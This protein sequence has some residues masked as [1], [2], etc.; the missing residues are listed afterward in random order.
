MN[1]A[2]TTQPDPVEVYRAVTPADCAE[3]S[4][5]L[6]AVGIRSATLF[7]APFYVLSVEHS[8]AP[9]AREQL[10]LYER[11]RRQPA[12]PAAA[13][14]LAGHPHAWI[15]CLVYALVLV[16]VGLSVSNGLW[17]PDAFDLG[18]L[19]AGRVH[20]GEWWR[21][22]TA[23]T[24]HLNGEHLGANLLVGS[25]FGYLAGRQQGAGHAWFLVVTGAGISNWIEA[26]LAPPGYRAVGASTAVFTTLGLVSAYTWGTGARWSRR[27][28]LQWAPLVSGTVLLAW[29]GSGDTDSV[30]QVD[31]VAHALGFVAGVLIGIAAARPRLQRLT[32][33]IPQW[34]TG[35]LAVLEII[36]AWSLALHS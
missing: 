25:L 4:L 13:M 26:L 18:A 29:F 22:W 34:S 11:E 27:W 15:G 30:G 24:L 20:A 14:R 16:N 12:P 23:L 10:A 35:M 6:D 5:V 36:G 21:A 2:A 28:A 31:V 9:R 17:R 1:E 32:R 3:R 7:V 8:D 33:V 19:D